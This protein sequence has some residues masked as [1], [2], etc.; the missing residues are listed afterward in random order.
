MTMS[1]EAYRA[2]MNAEIEA[3]ERETQLAHRR[4]LADL[5]DARGK[6]KKLKFTAEQ[7]GK[8]TVRKAQWNGD[9]QHKASRRESLNRDDYIPAFAT[10]LTTEHAELLVDAII[11]SSNRRCHATEILGIAF[12]YVSTTGKLPTIAMLQSRAYREHATKDR[13]ITSL[14]T[15]DVDSET[16]RHA[17]GSTCEEAMELREQLGDTGLLIASILKPRLAEA[18]MRC[19]TIEGAIQLAGVK[20]RTA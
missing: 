20:R 2:K 11:E 9:E 4:H 7:S 13:Q 6:G 14:S 16:L 17:I 8:R 12:E 5:R 10:I 18:I 3:I 19:S 1:L 15:I